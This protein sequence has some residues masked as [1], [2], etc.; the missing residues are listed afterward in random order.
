M[1]DG[2]VI[3]DSDPRGAFSDLDILRKSNLEPPAVAK[4]AHFFRDRGIPS[5]VISP[6]EFVLHLLRGG[7][8][9]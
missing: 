6:E 7:D 5:D 3:L 4:L 8:G 1:A 2:R 9:G